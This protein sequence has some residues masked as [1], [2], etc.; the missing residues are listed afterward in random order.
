MTWLREV[1]GTEKAV[2]AMCHLQALPGDPYYDKQRGMDYVVEMARKDLH[3]LQD[4]GVDA[5][6]FSNEFSLPYLTEVKTETVA[7]MARI[8][9]ELKSE[10]KIPFGVNVLWDAK[11]SLDLAAATGASFIREIFTGVYASDFGLWNTNVGETVRHQRSIGAENVKLLFNIVPEAAK[12]VADRDIESV[13]KS[14]VFNN[15]PDALCVSGL[16]AGARTDSQILERVKNAVPETVVLANTGVRR[17]NLVEQLTIAD[18]AVVGTAFKEDGIF[19]KQVDQARVKAF[20]D[21]VKAFR[22]R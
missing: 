16:T 1:L 17:D 2:I 3:A 9:G 12:Y 15:R 5:V 22:K 11:K 19:E 7:A 14:T 20:M 13:A 18:G 10:V 6:M 8:I 4:G 21:D